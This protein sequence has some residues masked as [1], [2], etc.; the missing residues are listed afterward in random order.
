[1]VF[2]L[3][4]PS[5]VFLIRSLTYAAVIA[6]LGGL[7]L[8]AYLRHGRE[9]K[10]RI[11][12]LTGDGERPAAAGADG[13]TLLATEQELLAPACFPWSRGAL[14]RRPRVTVTK[15]KL[16]RMPE[17]VAAA[18]L[19][20]AFAA[21]LAAQAP[22]LVRPYHVEASPPYV[23][24]PLTLEMSF[25]LDAAAATAWVGVA[26]APPDANAACAEKA[27]AFVFP[28]EC[29]GAAFDAAVTFTP[30]A[31]ERLEATRGG[32]PLKAEAYRLLFRTLQF[33]SYPL[34]DATA[35]QAPALLT[36]T[37]DTAVTFVV[38]ADGHPAD[39]RWDP[40]PGEATLYLS[41]TL[42]AAFFPR[43]LAG[44]RVRFLIG[45]PDPL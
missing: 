29:A 18:G 45:N 5:R 27:A 37:E 26:G 4:K 33:N 24:T 43:E 41:E 21:A 40:A 30:Y 38:G 10:P 7:A 19:E 14:E 23:V 35:A 16:T 17:G 36:A 44:A 25:D 2:V 31:Y 3:R 6:M 28:P 12:P 22:M 1:M 34:Y 13:R 42:G 32:A 20:E 15:V 11:P 9:S 39:V 8:W